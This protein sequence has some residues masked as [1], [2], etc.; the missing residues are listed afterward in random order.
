MDS[1]LFLFKDN[2]IIETLVKAFDFI[3]AIIL[4]FKNAGGFLIGLS[5]VLSLF[6]LIG[7]IYCVERL[8][9]LRIKE[10]EKYDL[11]V[12]PAIEK[13]TPGDMALTRRWEEAKKLIGSANENDWRQAI[14][15]C[16]IILDDLLEKMGYRGESV[17]EKLKRVV[18]GD[19]KS[20]SDAWEAHKI[21][22]QIAH[23][24]GFVLDHHI[25]KKVF[26]HY[27]KVFEEFYYV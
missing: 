16:D 18:T 22:N 20:L 25:A 6:F 17:G 24:S 19:M 10:E 11:K 15:N 8:K 23:E 13:A 5:L 2:I 14:I 4:F 3:P 7:I 1:N 26:S 21:R 27:R 12:E 9:I